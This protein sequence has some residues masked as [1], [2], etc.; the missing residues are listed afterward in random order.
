MHTVTSKDGTTI[1][2]DRMG[3]GSA[4][5]LVD[6]A[7]G[8][9]TDPNQQQLVRLL[10]EHFTVFNY[11][12]RGRGDSGNMQPYAVER[13]IEDIEALIAE[14]GGT[15]YVFGM[16][17]GAILALRAANQL[18][19]KVTTLSLYE[20][21][22]VLDDSRRPLPADYVQQLNAAIAEGN[23]SKAVEIFMTQAILIPKEYLAPMQSDPMWAGMEKVAHTLAYDG[24]VS[25]EFMVGRPWKNGT[26]NDTTA[27]TLVI[28]GENSESFFHTAAQTLANDL[29]EAEVRTLSGQD[30]NVA[31]DAL[32]PMLIAFFRTEQ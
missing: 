22:F 21:P 7:L 30:H 4:L 19:N 10:A 15:A 27:K 23:R 18:G 29:A 1:A 8:S 2:F 20:P 5:I 24:M 9:R 3:T 16:S 6:G 11:D 13:E 28:T 31:M 14:A 25:R 32:A 17:S 26:W 12:R